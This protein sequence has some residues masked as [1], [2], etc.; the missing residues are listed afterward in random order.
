LFSMGFDL[1][2]G[3][4]K[5]SACWEGLDGESLLNR[6]LIHV[7]KGGLTCVYINFMTSLKCSDRFGLISCGKGHAVCDFPGWGECADGVG[8]FDDGVG[9]LDGIWSDDVRGKLELCFIG[10]E[11][12][13]VCCVVGMDVFFGFCDPLFETFG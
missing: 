11:E 4:N 5:G 12:G 9:G 2:L 8:V 10:L 6:L 1:Q 3:L 7:K 13:V